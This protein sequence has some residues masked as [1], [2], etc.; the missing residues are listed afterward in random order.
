MSRTVAEG[1]DKF[2]T[3]LTPTAVHRTAAASHRATVEA[4]L[5]KALTVSAIRETGSFS[6]GT[7]VRH[8]ADVDVIVSIGHPKPAS[9]DTAL[10]WVRAALKSSFPTTSVYVRRPAVVV[11]FASGTER[12]EVIPGFYKSRSDSKTVSDIP[13][14][15][16]GWMDTAPLEHLDYVNE[17][18]KVE[19]ATGGAKKLA[20]L[21][22]AWKYYNNV[23]VSSF[24]LEM[25]AAEYMKT[26]K[27]FVAIYDVPALISSLYSKDLASMNDPKGVTGRFHATSSDTKLADAKSKLATANTRSQKALDAYTAENIDNAFYYL[28]LLFGGEFPA[29]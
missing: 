22:K 5:R 26:Q 12:W 21:I 29:R 14:A 15:A 25:R 10:E 7:G 1:F 16:S 17:A 4:S 18:N 3:D 27:S 20:R 11:D 13:A 23:P 19:G 8:H 24:Y 9:S 6:H 2:L 28:D